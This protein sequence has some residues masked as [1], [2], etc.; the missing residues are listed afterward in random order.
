MNIITTATG[1][2]VSIIC[3]IEGGVSYRNMKDGAE[4][5]PCR[6]INRSTVKAGSVGREILDAIEAAA[7]TAAT[8]VETEAEVAETVATQVETEAAEVPATQAEVTVTVETPGR[9]VARHGAHSVRI[10]RDGRGWQHAPNG[11][12]YASP[13]VAAAHW[14]WDLT[15][16]LIH[17]A[18]VA[19]TPLR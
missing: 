2:T 10:Y 11:D 3:D 1:R 14:A 13:E 4:Y 19:L 18:Q 17:P 8:Q 15:G 7:E 16:R 12:W 9:A 6:W 5:G